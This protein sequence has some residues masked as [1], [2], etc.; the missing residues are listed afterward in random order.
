MAFI[1][2]S[3]ALPAE[4]CY[5]MKGDLAQLVERQTV[6]SKKVAGSN[7]IVHVLSYDQ[8]EQSPCSK[9]IRNTSLTMN[10]VVTVNTTLTRFTSLVSG[11]VGEDHGGEGATVP[12]DL[13]M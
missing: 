8:D 2:Q 4:Q 11:D 1:R 10:V 6:E 13:V 3:G 9:F 12:G 5:K 7:P